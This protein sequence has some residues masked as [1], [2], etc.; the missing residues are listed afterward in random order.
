MTNLIIN[1]VN[2]IL[3]ERQPNLYLS[4]VDNLVFRMQF[5]HFKK[6]LT[7]HFKDDNLLEWLKDFKD[8][9]YIYYSF[10]L[11]TFNDFI[12]IT[13]ENYPFNYFKAKFVR[14]QLINFFN[15][16]NFLVEPFP[17]GNDLSVYEKIEDFNNEWSIYKRYDLLVR[18]NRKEIA[19]NVGSE[20]TL[21]SNQTKQFHSTDKIRIID[22]KDNFIKPLA[23]K[24]GV[25]NCRIIANKLKR[26]EL[27]ISNEPRKLN[28][29][30]LYNQL[31]SFYN[32]HLLSIDKEDFKIEAGGLKN[33]EQTDLNKVNINENLML[34][35]K[36]KTDINA[37]TGMRDYGIYK[38]SPK[39]TDV[40]F[41]FVY[42][43][44]RDANQLYLYL[45]NGLKHYPGLWSYVGIPIRLSDIKLQYNGIDDL[46]NKI[47]IFISENLNDEYYSDLFAIV[48]NPNSSQEKEELD[49]DEDPTYYTVKRKFLEK[50]IPTQFIQDKN[51]HSGSF[52]YFLPNISIGILAKLGGVP[53]RLKTKR[54][55]ELVI[56]FNQKTIGEHQFIGS[57]VFFSNDGQLGK[58][59]GFPE[60]NSETTLI[61]N[62]KSAIEQYISQKES[63]PERLVI[64]YYKPQSGKEQKSIEDLI[65]KELRLNIPFAIVEINDSKSQMDICFDKDFSMG[66]PESGTY[67]RVS[68]TEY[69][70]FNNTRYQ[71][72][73][74]RSVAEELPIKIAI[75][76]AD[77]GGFSH[78]DLISQVYEFSRLYWKGLKQRSQPA[79]TIYSKLIA[80]FTANYNGELPNNDT[81]NNTPWFL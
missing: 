81:V 54:T 75:H 16:R 28:Y 59:F 69:L 8:E 31:I 6:R 14:E 7:N 43:N 33:V 51:I 80:E 66:M 73:P 48:I 21:I 50:G 29:K 20:K 49:E 1:R 18:T 45:K 53:W 52:H 70:L 39:A 76:F 32:N 61:G 37:V 36:E 35:G 56:G 23:G 77:T 40:K 68:K 57:A 38:P 4:K 10:T 55:D 11:P 15:S 22:T 42:E 72:N 24:E 30:N 34:F 62:L 13:A 67:V 63:P 9:D 27:G 26:D 60:T 44:S 19:F 25:N 71:K 5:I 17:K 41:I 78:R 12:T 2:Y 58:T 64:H 74:L 46:K 65:Q 79:T 47:D 3:S